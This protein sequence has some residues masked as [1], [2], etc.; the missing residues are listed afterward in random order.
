MQASDRKQ[1]THCSSP[2]ANEKLEQAV[3][4]FFFSF[5]FLIVL[6]CLSVSQARGL[7][8]L[9][10]RMGKHPKVD[11]IA[12]PW[13]LFCFC[14]FG[15]LGLCFEI[16]SHCTSQTGGKPR[17]SCSSLS[18]A[19]IITLLVFRENFCPLPYLLVH[20]SREHF[21]SHRTPE[22]YRDLWRWSVTWC[23]W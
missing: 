6:L 23:C 11:F 4:F 15:L 10:S 12:S 14:S 1:R 13:V 17:S 9:G 20:L 22:N 3:C 7:T 16:I 21:R 8:L 2:S 18:R 5:F 19:G